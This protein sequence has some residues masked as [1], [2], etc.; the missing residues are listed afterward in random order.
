[1][2][3]HRPDLPRRD[4]A[5]PGRSR[6]AH[7]RG[8]LPRAAAMPC[9]TGP[10]TS[11][12]SRRT[13]RSPACARCSTC[14]RSAT[15][16]CSRRLRSTS[17]GH[18]WSPPAM[19]VSRSSR[20]ATARQH[21]CP[22]RSWRGSPS[23]NP[24]PNWSTN[25]NSPCRPTNWTFAATFPT[26][27]QTLAPDEAGDG[28]IFRDSVLARVHFT[29]VA[30]TGR[31]GTKDLRITGSMLPSG[32][33]SPYQDWVSPWPLNLAGSLTMPADTSAPPAVEARATTSGEL[34]IEPA[35]TL[36]APGFGIRSVVGLDPDRAEVSAFSE[37][38][39]VGTLDLDMGKEQPIEAE[40]SAPL[41][42]SDRTW[43]LTVVFDPYLTLSARACR[44][45]Q[46][47]RRRTRPDRGRARADQPRH[48]RPVDGGDGD[49]PQVSRLLTGLAGHHHRLSAGHLLG[50][51]DPV[52]EGRRPGHPMGALPS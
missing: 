11:P 2:R 28:L 3:C 23:P 15:A 25:S 49:H 52:R 40:I 17:T 35:T 42:V 31:T 6:N 1:M 36:H 47:V 12:P 5:T 8:D 26:L 10:S 32:A 9:V 19:R 48:L 4:S 33:V 13:T 34:P 50:R 21:R 41:L 37:L 29:G 38:T 27:A 20:V 46:A 14:S 24:R 51:A 44:D 22:P 43:R 39:V 16:S 18:R 7:P 45:R 30:L